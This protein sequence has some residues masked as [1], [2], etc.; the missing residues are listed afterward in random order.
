MGNN[1]THS[2]ERQSPSRQ[3]PPAIVENDFDP[4]MAFADPALLGWAVDDPHRNSAELLNITAEEVAE[5]TAVCDDA[6]LASALMAVT[7]GRIAGKVLS[8]TGFLAV[9]TLAAL[10]HKMTEGI[11][12]IEA[13]DII[14]IAVSARIGERPEASLGSLE[15][16]G[17]RLVN[18]LEW[19]ATDIELYRSPDGRG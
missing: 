16:I 17:R 9:R 12:A 19:A 6:G 5:I 1:Q 15:L 18:E 13:L 4:D 2:G 10:V 14:L 8:P 7:D 3:A 11:C